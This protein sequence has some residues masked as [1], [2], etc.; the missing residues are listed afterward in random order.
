[1]GY[2]TCSVQ[3]RGNL[4]EIARMAYGSG[5]FEGRSGG[6]GRMGIWQ[7]ADGK[8]RVVKYNTH[9]EKVKNV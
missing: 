1:M 5:R 9:F 3:A 8:C 7:T 2:E 4:Q 6:A